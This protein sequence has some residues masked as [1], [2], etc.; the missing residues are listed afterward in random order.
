MKTTYRQ[1]YKHT[2][3]PNSTDEEFEQKLLEKFLVERGFPSNLTKEELKEIK[4]RSSVLLD[5]GS[6]KSLAEL[7]LDE[8]SQLDEEVPWGDN[9][10]ADVSKP[11]KVVVNTTALEASLERAKHAHKDQ[12]L[13]SV[14]VHMNI[15]NQI[16]RF[17]VF[18]TEREGA[19][20]QAI[21][22]VLQKISVSAM[23]NTDVVLTDIIISLENPGGEDSWVPISITEF[24]HRTKEVFLTPSTNIMGLKT[25]PK[26]VQLELFVFDEKGSSVDRN[27]ML[28]TPTTPHAE[29][30]PKPIPVAKFTDVSVDAVEDRLTKLWENF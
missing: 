27:L 11:E 12:K 13:F 4:I 24:L 5:E 10:V 8:L 6:E 15:N 26:E 3:Y 28:P 7:F 23:S 30:L 16:R 18:D 17:E 20:T 19:H 9:F 2:M 1:Y 25:V 22:M 29:T 21:A 14:Y